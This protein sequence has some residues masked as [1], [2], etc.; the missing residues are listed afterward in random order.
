M[1][2]AL[3]IDFVSDFAC[4][5][6]AIGLRGSEIALEQIGDVA[7]PHIAFHPFE[8]NP[9]MPA[10]GRATALTTS[11]LSMGAQRTRRVPTVNGSMHVRP[12]SASRRAA[13]TPAARI[14]PS[15]LIG[16]WPGLKTKALTG[17]LIE[18]E[19]RGRIPKS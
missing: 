12:K 13:R 3:K 11:Q 10:G 15:T 5:W 4:P 1:T 19:W 16:Y 7:E 14:T 18:V 8:P 2:K 9:D 6:C 17:V